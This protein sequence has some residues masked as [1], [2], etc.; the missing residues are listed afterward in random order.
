MGP[1]GSPQNSPFD[2][3]ILTYFFLVPS[4]ITANTIIN[5]L[6]STRLELSVNPVKI[7]AKGIMKKILLSLLLICNLASAAQSVPASTQSRIVELFTADNCIAV[8]DLVKAKE[9]FGLRPNIMAIVAYCEIPGVDSL[10]LFQKAEELDPVGD[11]IFTLH[12]KYVWKKDPAA[13]E[14]LW[15]RVLMLAR[16]PYLS[17]MARE[18]LAGMIKEDKPLSLQ[19]TTFFASLM[20]GGSAESNA[21]PEELAYAPNASSPTINVEARLNAQ[22]W[23]PFGSIAAN[24]FLDVE[25]RPSVDQYS[26]ISHQVDLP[27]SVHVGRNEDIVFRPIGGFTNLNGLPFKSYAGIGVLGIIYR[28]DYKQSIQGLFY[29]DHISIPQIAGEDAEHYH[30][31]YSWEFY[32]RGWIVTTQLEIEHASADDTT[33]YAGI[34]GTFNNSHTDTVFDFK[35]QKE[36]GILTFGL[37]GKAG[38]RLDSGT[39]RYAI[40]SSGVIVKTSRIDTQTVLKPSLTIPIFPYVQLYA[41]YEWNRIF[42]NIGPDDYIDRNF[43]NQTVGL[44][45]KTYLSSY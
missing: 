19:K 25:Q 41:W 42:S 4:P 28:A 40:R 9:V 38:L 44:A 26:L 37:V 32:P 14:P 27:I 23:F 18:Y 30:F 16:N 39:S 33:D 24:Y 20:A 45:L 35:L 6:I 36:L 43:S 2:D 17:A 7:G 31:D 11:L 5:Y 29:S 34:P 21:R 3:S 1:K 15:Q 13:A 22:R 10:V 12:A 8:R